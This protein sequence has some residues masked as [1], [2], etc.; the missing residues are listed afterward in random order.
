LG[1][2]ALTTSHLERD[3]ARG[4][5]DDRSDA[6]FIA[7][8]YCFAMLASEFESFGDAG[9]VVEETVEADELNVF[10]DLVGFGAEEC[11]PG[12]PVRFRLEVADRSDGLAVAALLFDDDETAVTHCHAAHTFGGVFDPF[13]KLQ[14]RHVACRLRG[15]YMAPPLATGPMWSTWIAPRVM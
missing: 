2:P 15:S 5:Q 13:D 6:P 11:K 9:F 3:R 8:A 10:S 1:K 7:F 14:R 4:A 12:V